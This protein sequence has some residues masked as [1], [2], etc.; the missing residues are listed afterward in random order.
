MENNEAYKYDQRVQLYRKAYVSEDTKFAMNS[1]ENIYRQLIM[2]DYKLEVAFDALDQR[3]KK[4]E[5]RLDKLQ[6]TKSDS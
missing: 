4:I 1:N 5:E 2:M 6:A 3:F